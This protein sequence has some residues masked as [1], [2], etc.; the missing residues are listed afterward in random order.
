ML[1][2]DFLNKYP[3]V[4]PEQAPLLILYIKSAMCVE[5]NGKDTKHTRNIARRIY[6]VRNGKYC[7][8]HKIVWCERGLELTENVT[9]NGREDEFNPRLG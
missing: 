1:N 7:N 6:L 8:L 4:V 5:N 9:K 2:N 3:Y